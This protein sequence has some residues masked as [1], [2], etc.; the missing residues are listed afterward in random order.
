[1]KMSSKGK[2]IFS[3]KADAL[4]Y[5]QRKVKNSKIE[6]MYVFNHHEW[7]N[8]NSD[9]LN[10]I[11]NIFS[12]KIVVRSSTIGEDSLEKSDAGKY[13]T[14]LDLQVTQRNTIKNAINEVI[15]SYNISEKD[16]E[17]HQILIQKQTTNS[18]TSGVIFTRTPNNGSPYYVIN[19]EDG[20]KT[21][22]I[23]SGMIGNTVKIFRGISQ[24]DI[25]KKWHKLIVAVKEIEKLSKNDKLDIEFAIT[26]RDI[27]IFQVRPL[28]MIRDFLDT[29]LSNRVSTEIKNNQEELSRCK[30]TIFSNMTDWNPAEIIGDRPNRL[31]YSIY[32]FLIMRNSWS[33]GRELLGYHNP[34]VGLMKKFSGRAY[35]NV[36]ASFESL[37]P[38]DMNKELRK[39]LVK[40]FMYKLEREPYLHDKVEFEILFTCYDFSFKKRMNELLDHGFTKKEINQISDI[41]LTFTNSLIKITP[42]IQR[43]TKKSLEVLEASREKWDKNLEYYKVKLSIADDLL[44][45]CRKFGAI[46]FSAIARL[47]F[48]ARILLYTLVDI[49]DINRNDIEKFMNSISTPVTE[50][51]NDLYQLKINKLKKE[52]FLKK[53]GHLRPGTYDIT[54][55]RY[56]KTPKFFND[57]MILEN[58]KPI[59]RKQPNLDVKEILK[60]NGLIF[61]DIEF[62][63]FVKETMTLRE[64]SKFEFTRTLSDILE[65]IA[66]AGKELGFSRIELSMLSLNDISKFKIMKKE[67]LKKFWKK[68]IK[69]Y[70]IQNQIE[71]YVH[72]PSILF[73][74]ND[75]TIIQD[76]IAKPNFITNK[77]IIS[78]NIFLKDLDNLK[79]IENKIVMI[80]NA[81]PGFDWIFTKNPSGLITKYGGM[82]SHMAIRCAELGLPAAIGCGETLFE[83]L[84]ESKKISMDC[85]KE[86]ILI[87]EYMQENDYSDEK[88]LLKSLGYIK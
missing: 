20:K 88:K 67:E 45:K 58:K 46:H 36:K 80:D 73:S 43:D 14:I 66:D 9:I 55:N 34:R 28:T 50:F 4:N 19:Y 69:K 3:S 16:S 6:K 27:V 13:K 59:K 8:E 83:K 5:F 31:D 75:F 61:Q 87:L 72:L 26:N 29:K 42:K 79:R 74:R 44:K 49:S 77:K 39:K 64:E 1:M 52:K 32:D 10:K 56:D 17:P 48:V 7:K 82:A 47:A 33:D 71:Q 84:K 11:Q 37:L 51:Q 54:I 86:D 38:S 41:L 65:L 81:D 25:P 12:G 15:S 40:F 23:T 76:Y 68:Q 70:R 2:N 22:S 24:K 85:K 21:D 53:Y 62:F 63:N 30:K 60:K 57:L 35:V 18:K 78:E